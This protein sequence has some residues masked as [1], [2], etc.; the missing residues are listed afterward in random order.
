MA[1]CS[2]LAHAQYPHTIWEFDGTSAEPGFGSTIGSAGDVNL[3]GYSDILV[4]ISG[5]NHV[6]V[7]SGV[8]GTILLTVGGPPG[9][10]SF[11]AQVCGLGDQNGD[12]VPDFA[13]SDPNYERAGMLN[14]GAV[15]VF[16]GIS[17]E[18]LWQDFGDDAGWLWGS[19]ICNAGDL[20]N[21][22]ISDLA[23]GSEHPAAEQ[24]VVRVFTGGTG[25]LLYE[26]FGITNDAKGFGCAL[27]GAGSRDW[28]S[29]Y[30]SLIVG[31]YLTEVWGLI[32][33]GEALVFE[34]P[35]GDLVRRRS[36]TEAYN[37]FGKSL[38]GYGDVDRDGVSDYLV[39]SPD[40]DG[41]AN[42]SGKVELLSYDPNPILLWSRSGTRDY[43]HYGAITRFCGDI[44]GDGIDDVLV[45]N[46]DDSP[47]WTGPGYVD[48]LSGVDGHVL[49]SLEGKA[50]GQLFGT[51]IAPAGD[52]DGDGY[53]DLMVNGWDNIFT[54]DGYLRVYGGISAAHELGLLTP[55]VLTAGTASL[56]WVTGAAPGSFVSLYIGTG[57][58]RSFRDSALGIENASTVAYVDAGRNGTARMNIFLPPS[59][60]GTPI[61]MQA[62]NHGEDRLSNIEFRI[63]R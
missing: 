50:T 37:H 41:G 55:S 48:V 39:G 12:G 56:N 31:A 10:H 3:D 42:Q 6:R 38:D 36:G 61:W 44:D 19:A 33:A 1:F 21:D 7:Y 40:F 49:W 4:G 51:T 20:N 45:G 15:G 17:G 25:A 23:I 60:A 28:F 63:V 18:L 30:G 62:S 58:G 54:A 57:L 9:T 32:E 53:E 8:D 14:V 26:V 27:A 35:S 52:V 47:F 59:F 46:L 5:L 34:G 24:G 22:G 16:S 2:G 13:V 29:S 11:G 43:E